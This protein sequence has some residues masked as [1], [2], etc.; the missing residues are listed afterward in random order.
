MVD[1]ESPTRIIIT[2]GVLLSYPYRKFKGFIGAEIMYGMVAYAYVKE[3]DS[4]SEWESEYSI[5]KNNI[6]KYR[7]KKVKEEIGM[8]IIDYRYPVVEKKMEELLDSLGFRFE[9][10][11]TYLK[12]YGL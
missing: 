8:V 1:R 11:V 9:Y 4:E 5:I 12:R 7:F 3:Y 6:T 2:K 10:Y